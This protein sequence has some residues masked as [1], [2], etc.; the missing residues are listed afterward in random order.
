[1]QALWGNLSLEEED[2]KMS[3]NKKKNDPFR[4]LIRGA[5]ILAA[6]AAVCALIF[7]GLNAVEGRVLDQKIKD[8][9]T[10]NQNREQQY[11]AALAEY[12]SATQKGQNIN[13]PEAKKEG[14]DILDLSTYAIDNAKTDQVDRKTLL[15]SGL[16]LINQWHA[17]PTDYYEHLADAKSVMT[18]SGKTVAAADGNV[19][20]FTPAI[21]ALESMFKD[22]AS[23]GL[24]NV[25]VAAGLRT[26]ERQTEMFENKKAQ[27]ENS[28]SGDMLIEK[29][30]EQVNAPGTSDY[31]SG[32]SFDLSLYPNP[33]QLSFQNTDQGK[34]VTENSWRYGIIFRF[35][36]QDFPNSS[37]VDKS[38]KTGVSTKLNL[39][40][41]VG[42]PHAAVMKQL[43]L[44]LEEYI[45]YLM[46][47]PHLAVYENGDLKYEIY[48]QPATNAEVETI[49]VPLAATSY[50][51]S[52]D[53]MGGIVTAFFFD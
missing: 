44:C 46:A 34:W 17:L 37:W 40:R 7:F 25:F 8:T 13:W 14:W 22:A 48:R 16:M 43:D 9:Q 42:T 10:L 50:I 51:T 28:F 2:D 18:E 52:L 3:R 6:A 41:W 32:F 15:T 38:Y 29:T 47:H 39:Y 36:T 33:D 49:Q 21:R 30:K 1:M 23:A 27:L 4:T 11:N 35:P 12:Q 53:N 45:E 19:M 31:H 20:L 24:N 5:A 26:L